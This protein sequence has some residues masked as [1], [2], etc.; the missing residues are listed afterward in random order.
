MPTLR[1]TA[2]ELGA[3]TISKLSALTASRRKDAAF[4]C[5]IQWNNQGG[6]RAEGK[7]K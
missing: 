4:P 2:A 3:G 1:S 6:G 5:E 7:Y